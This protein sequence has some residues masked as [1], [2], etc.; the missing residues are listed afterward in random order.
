MATARTERLDVAKVDARALRAF[1]ESHVDAVFAF[2]S[3]RLGDRS[4]AEEVS[5]ETWLRVARSW[6][7]SDPSRAWVF[8]IAR[9][10]V[11]DRW[12]RLARERALPLEASPEHADSE[13]EQLA[14]R[15]QVLNALAEL[16][17]DESAALVLRFFEDRP[18]AEVA[19]LLGRSER[20]AESLLT[21][22]KRHF[23]AE[24]EVIE[25]A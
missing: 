7:R 19:E 22:A 1:Y 20:G 15:T 10:L 14:Q 21:R 6:S 24:W 17:E 4:A 16:P 23:E 9:N 11:T 18:I 2:L 13:V 5:Q 8:T 12:R 3:A 25:N